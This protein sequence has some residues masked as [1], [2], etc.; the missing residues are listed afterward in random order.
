MSTPEQVNGD[1]PDQEY[2][3]LA[4][5]RVVDMASLYAGPLIAT[6]L[7]DF[8]ADVVKVEHPRGDDARR[9][10]RS[11]DGVPLWWKVISR[12]K[13]L[14]ALDLHRTEDRDIAR[15]LCAW[16]DV[17]IENFR[18]GRLESWQMGYD[19][20][21]ARN[22]GLVMVR[23]TG[24]GQTGPYADRPGFGTL[25]EAFSGFAAITGTADGPPTLP[26]F[27]LADGVAALT[28]TSAVLAALRWRDRQGA[29]RGQVVDLSLYEPLFN[30]LGPQVVE[31]DQLGILQHRQGNRS[32]RTAPRNAYRTADDRWV[33]LSAG[34]QQIAN[35]VFAAIG[36]PELAEDE[37]FSQPAGRFANAELVDAIVSEWI[38]GHRLDEV[39]AAFERF[40]A[41]IAPVY[42][43][44]QIVTDPQF[45]ARQSIVSV[46]DSDLG[47]VRM[48]N[49][50]P[51]LSRTPG[52]IRRTG[53][54][55]IDADR[56]AVLAR[57]KAV[58]RDD[59]GEPR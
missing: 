44:D 9:W 46:P 23:V 24:F 21:A 53:Q 51:K 14:I 50:V 57:L 30:I 4:G 16:A 5:L 32:P 31:Y 36:Q 19:D 34:T 56:Q 6:I 33:A 49:V 26:P 45:L 38:G 3:A 8:G 42:E 22:P 2:A 43:T 59:Q 17:V 54:T 37:R 27:G 40:Q 47:Q 52:Q 39:L 1:A 58:R 15:D 18:P 48:Q 25:A 28:G 7:A 13:D 10:G 35:R 20:L 41:P 11:R 12:N 55:A 29:G